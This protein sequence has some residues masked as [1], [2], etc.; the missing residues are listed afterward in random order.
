MP[1]PIFCV[2][3]AGLAGGRAAV[4]LRDRGF[5]GRLLLIGSEADPPYERPPLSK[6]YLRGELLRDKL[7]ISTPESYSALS[8]EWRPQAT[9]E[10][11]ARGEHQLRLAGG[12]RI[13]FDRLLLA[14]GSRPRTIAAPG[15]QLPGV[16]TYRTIS[17]ADSFRAELEHQPD[18]V[19]VGGGFLGS[20]LA[21]AARRRGCR[22][23]LIEAGQALLAPLGQVVGEYCADLHR[24]A[25]VELVF[26]ETVA[27]FQGGT[28]LEQVLLHGGR[29]LPC[30]L[31][32][33]CVGAEPNSELAAEAR[34][35]VDSGV[36]IDVNCRSSDEAIFAAGDVASRWSP[37]WNRRLRVEHYDNAHL[38]G[39]YVAGAMLD[40]AGIYDPV[41]YFWTEQY[42]AMVQLVGVFEPGDQEVLRGEPGSGR[43]SVFYLRQGSISACVA[44]N[45]FQDLSAARRLIGSRIAVDEDTLSKSSLDL[46]EWSHRAVE[47]VGDE[48]S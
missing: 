22:V 16:V 1:S 29:I 3:G 5:D 42:D 40:E 41:P 18:V 17:D 2:V 32:L 11:I 25:G 21:V 13:Q 44:V 20:E 27:S 36:L 23:T 45:R 39:L 30:D 31:A 43:F 8:I 47:E 6:S 37:R 9:V 12:E 15:A 35:D 14:T 19:V 26:G 24:Q 4:S 7:F 48:R 10:A 38:Q 33:V 28:R 34:L 46:R